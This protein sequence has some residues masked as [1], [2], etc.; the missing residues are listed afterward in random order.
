[1]APTAEAAGTATVQ[2][3]TLGGRVW[4]MRAKVPYQLLRNASMALGADAQQQMDELERL[5]IFAVRKDT[6]DEFREF[7]ATVPEDDDESVIDFRDMLAAFQE[8]AAKAT[9]AP[10]RSASESSDFSNRRNTASDYE[11]NSPS[12]ASTPSP[13]MPPT[14]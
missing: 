6:R 11:G 9:G 12:M 10:F 2:G 3:F 8:V 14:S 13:L 1:M 7:L 5:L 4:P